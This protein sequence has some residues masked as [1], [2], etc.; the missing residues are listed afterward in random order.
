MYSTYSM[1]VPENFRVMS[2]VT[3]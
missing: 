3:F 1:G 2:G